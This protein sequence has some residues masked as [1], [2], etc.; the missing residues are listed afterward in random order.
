MWPPCWYDN[1]KGLFSRGAPQLQRNCSPDYGLL[2]YLLSP[3][4]LIGI[5]LELFCL[6]LAWALIATSIPVHITGP[7]NCR[8]HN[9]F[10]R[11]EHRTGA[12]D[13]QKGNQGKYKALDHKYYIFPQCSRCTV[14]SNSD[15][16]LIWMHL[17]NHRVRFVS[18]GLHCKLD[19]VQIQYS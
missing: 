8:F 10:R 13:S 4:C 14:V 6:Q 17:T 1:N 15:L 7:N 2:I 3:L 5:G 18:A 19:E 16:G 12:S 9:K 11:P